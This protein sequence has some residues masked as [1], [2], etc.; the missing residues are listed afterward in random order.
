MYEE[1]NLMC[2][3]VLDF[4]VIPLNDKVD[5]IKRIAIPKLNDNIEI[6]NQII[7][8]KNL[9]EKDVEYGILLR[10]LAELNIEIYGMILSHNIQKEV[11]LSF[12]ELLVKRMS[13]YENIEKYRINYSQ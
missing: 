2:E 3:S 8:I 11:N 12:S 10:E 1:N 4:E 7:A 13:I 5:F 6:A 9:P